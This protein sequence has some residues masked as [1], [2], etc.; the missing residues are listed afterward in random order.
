MKKYLTVALAMLAVHFTADA[1]SAFTVAVN[2]DGSTRPS[3]LT[4]L[5]PG[6]VNDRL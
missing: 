5:N 6:S 4:P 3:R 2:S 1:W